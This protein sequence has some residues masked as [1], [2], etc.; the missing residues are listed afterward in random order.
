MVSDSIDAIGLLMSE[1]IYDLVVRLHFLCMRYRCQVRFI[2]ISGTWIIGQ[3]TNGLYRGILYE[4]VM[5]GKTM[6]LFLPLRELA[7]N[8]SDALVSWIQQ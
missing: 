7:L 4:R 3:G 6:L 5:N 8:R 2:H 1:T